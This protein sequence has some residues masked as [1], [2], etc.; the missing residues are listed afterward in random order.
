MK[1][2]HPLLLRLLALLGA[3]LIRLLMGTVRFRFDY[4]RAGERHPA[5]WRRRRFVYAIWHESLLFG[6]SLRSRLTTLVSQHADGEL[7]TLICR[8]LGLGIVRGSTTRGGGQGM[9]DLVHASRSSH[10]VVTPDGPRGPR[11]RVQP[12]LVFLA[13]RCGLPIVMGGV[14]YS[15]AWRARS[16]DRF[17]IPWPGS[18]AY[19]VVSEPIHVPPDL[20]RRGLERYRRL[21]E[22]RFLEVTEAAERWAAGGRPERAA[23][24]PSLRAS[25]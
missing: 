5:D 18:T 13:S 11:R 20:D 24:P 7:I 1:L 25:A 23:A 3:V 21:V 2:R 4:R 9:L 17:V 22:E 8:L 15:R 19:C 12:G 10:V 14:G 16:W 6:V